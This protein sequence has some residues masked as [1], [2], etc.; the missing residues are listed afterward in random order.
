MNLGTLKQLNKGYKHLHFMALLVAMLALT[1][2]KTNRRLIREPVKAEGAEYLF[3]QLKDHELKYEWLSMRFSADYIQNK[4]KTSFKGQIRIQKDRVIWVSISPALGIEALR[5]MI[6]PDSVKMLNRVESNYFCR[7]F[8]Y[9]NQLVNNAID[10]DMLQAFLIGND[11]QFYENGKFKADVDGKGYKL[12]TAG[13]SK[14]KKYVKKNQPLIHI[15]IQNIW[16]SPETFKITEVMVKEIQPDHSRKME[17]F[18]S[19]FE[20]LGNQLMPSLLFFE[21]Q[22]EN[23]L[24][25][26]LDYSKF[27]VDKP[28][29]FPFRV[30]SKYKQIQ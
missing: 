15:P 29:R 13:R 6:T 24:T 16:L 12:S 28:L 1:S 18:Y 20:P 23:A 3:Q 17:A 11:F 10:F 7:D 19:Q 4:K 27:I 30:P 26:E 8:G 2:C 21:I 5:L 14:L 9:I 22:S 25:I